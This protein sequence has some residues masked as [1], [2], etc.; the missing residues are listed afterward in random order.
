LAALPMVLRRPSPRPR[1]SP[2]G[3]FGRAPSRSAPW[4]WATARDRPPRSLWGDGRGPSR[5]ARSLQGDGRGPSRPARSL[6]GDGRGPSRP[7]RSLGGDG[8]LP[9]A[10]PV[11]SG[12]RRGGRRGP[13]RLSRPAGPSPRGR[14]RPRPVRAPRPS[15]GPRET[16]GGADASGTQ[17]PGRRPITPGAKTTIV[18]VPMKKDTTVIPFFA[19]ILPSCRAVALWPASLDRPAV[20]TNHR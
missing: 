17:R 4:V 11:P 6:Q 12:R 19:I 18:L 10:R 9:K 15:G 1:E 20:Q 8:G 13:S 2:E 7:A 16:R 3:R 5:P 14:G